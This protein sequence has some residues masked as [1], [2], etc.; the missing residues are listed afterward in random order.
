MFNNCNYNFEGFVHLNGFKNKK[1]FIFMI[2]HKIINDFNR[3]D[4]IE[5]I[6]ENFEQELEIEPIY[7][8]F[9]EFLKNNTPLPK[10]T[11]Q[12]KGKLL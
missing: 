2:K 7:E 6:N 5:K 11:F 10:K 3:L 4:L 1:F 12:K 9:V 8:R